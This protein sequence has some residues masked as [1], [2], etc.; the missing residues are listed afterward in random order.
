M[1]ERHHTYRPWFAICCVILYMAGWFSSP[2]LEGLHFVSHATGM[3]GGAYESHHFHSHDGTHEHSLLNF[4]KELAERTTGDAVPSEGAGDQLFKKLPQL[5]PTVPV[6]RADWVG[7]RPAHYH[8]LTF[9]KSVYLP[10][11]V[12]PPQA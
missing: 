12:P 7:D 2:M 8:R 9:F 10:V 3:A 5:A 4:M 1:I 6:V 11:Q